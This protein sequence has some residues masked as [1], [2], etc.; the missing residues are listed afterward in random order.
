VTKWIFRCPSLMCPSIGMTSAGEGFNSVH[1]VE[2]SSAYR[3]EPMVM[4][5]RSVVMRSGSSL[6]KIIG[7]FFRM[8]HIYLKMPAH[9]CRFE[10]W[11]IRRWIFP[12]FKLSFVKAIAFSMDERC[13]QIACDSRSDEAMTSVL[14]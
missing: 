11:L 9:I 13:A 10:L 2:I 1:R 14:L 4:I 7:G 6:T 5:T 3:L 8:S 12:R